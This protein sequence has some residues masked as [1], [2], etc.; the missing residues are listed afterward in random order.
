MKNRDGVPIVLF[1]LLITLLSAIA[2]AQI[3]QLS[4]DTLGDVAP[5]Y[6]LR[7][8][9]ASNGRG[10][11]VAWEATADVESDVTSIY[12]RVLGPDGVPLRPSPTFLGL[13]R[14]PRVVWNGHEYLA[15]WGITA[16][17]RGPLPS[18]SVVG[19]RVREDGS[20][21]DASPVTIISESNPFSTE[22]TLDWTGSQYLVTWSRGIAVVDVDLQHYNLVGRAGGVPFYAASLGDSF[23][24]LAAV[25]Q[26]TTGWSLYVMPFSSTGVL[27]TV[28]LLK[29]TRG[30]IVPFDDT[31]VLI[32]DDETNLHYGQL[33]AGGQMISTLVLGPGRLGFPRLATRG[34]RLVG[35]WEAFIDNTHTRVCTMRSETIFQPV[36]SA[37][38]AGLQ[39]DPAIGT[40]STS[41]LAAWS[42]RANSRDSVRVLQSRVSEAPHIEGGLGRSVSD[43]SETPVA[44]RRADGSLAVAWSEYNQSTKHTE[45]HLGGKSGQARV[46]DRA[47]FADDFD[48][49]SPAIAAGLGRTMAVWEEG[50]AASS[51]VRMT[52]VNDATKS[53]IATLP[54]GAGSAPSVAFD[55]REWLAAWQSP[56]GVIRFALINS[57]GSV[58]ASGA[59]PAETIN[60]STQTTPAVAWSGKSFFVTWR[61]S[62]AAG[63]GTVPGERIEIATV[64]TAGVASASRTIDRA[65]AG[66]GAPSIAANGSRLLVSW[67]TESPIVRQTLFDDSGKQLSGF[68]DF[69]WPSAVSR[70]RT[71]AMPNG[72][73]MFA[74]FAGN[75]IA[76]T[77][78]EGRA[79]DAFDVP[80]VAAGGDFAANAD[81]RFDVVYSR[82]A[83]QSVATFAQTVG[84]PR[85]LPRRHVSGH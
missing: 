29:A 31:Y 62:V 11:V 32:W 75:R 49:T 7:T 22:I 19:V 83:S 67:G 69:A 82:P 44:E 9:V 85:A 1:F 41:I 80:E 15:A 39:H 37:V 27:G 16:G 77:S 68:I 3:V 64:N 30:N 13:G 56:F 61:E 21:I 73:A 26:S 8:S 76:L 58:M 25:Y 78:Y 70:T 35:S 53:V 51:T 72:Y 2:D 66:L 59:M 50:P 28:S 34:R 57:E 74:V 47:V 33:T 6:R 23:V 55:G 52:I 12:I 4:L 81:G 71:R 84:S 20:L 60:S 48:Q 38:S 46:P 24:V 36:C 42:D 5:P 54:L 79:L 18:P 65:D 45:I 14:E 63:A 43:P 40:S 17:D 10:Y